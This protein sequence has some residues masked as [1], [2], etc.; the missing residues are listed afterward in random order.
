[1]GSQPLAAPGNVSTLALNQLETARRHFERHLTEPMT[2]DL[3]GV[4]Q[5]FKQ[6]DCLE[7][8]DAD[9]RFLSSRGGNYAELLATDLY[10]YFL[11]AFAALSEDQ[12]IKKWDNLSSKEEH[13]GVHPHLLRVMHSTEALTCF[14]RDVITHEKE[15]N[16]RKAKAE[17]FL[18]TLQ[19]CLNEGDFQ[20]AFCLYMGLRSAQVDTFLDSAKDQ[21]EACDQL[22]SPFKNHENLRQAQKDR[23]TAYLPALLLT[24]KDTGILHELDKILD[25]DKPTSKYNFDKLERIQ[26]AISKFLAPREKWNVKVAASQARGDVP[27][28]S[29][30]SEILLHYPI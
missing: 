24:L 19:H 18:A 11:H 22:F 16:T 27:K 1:M 10:H 30:V 6:V 17:L 20:S 13:K 7:F 14:V 2:N 12:S 3:N 8:F 23:T 15:E 25:G 21:L 26:G 5:P 9:W 28:T 4:D 29:V